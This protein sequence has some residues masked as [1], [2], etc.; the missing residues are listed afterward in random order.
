MTDLSPA[1]E[2]AVAT[3]GDRW[4]LLIVAALMDGPQRFGELQEAI[5]GLAPNVLSARLRH[6]ERHGVIVSKPYSKRPLRVS[7][8]LTA[9]GAELAGAI[10]LLVAWEAGMGAASGSSDE[11]GAP[12][13]EVCGTPLEPRWWCN[14][15]GRAA[16]EEEVDVS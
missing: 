1:L 16:D 3:V 8:S 10:R 7:Y 4:S 6:L 5:P 15:C 13:H 11:V 12:L 9:R 2:R 14:T